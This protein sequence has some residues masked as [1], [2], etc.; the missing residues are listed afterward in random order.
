MGRV[1]STTRPGSYT[2]PRRGASA[3]RQDIPCICSQRRGSGGALGSGDARAYTCLG[4]PPTEE[5]MQE[6]LYHKLTILHY[7]LTSS[8]ERETMEEPIG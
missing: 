5:Y 6:K 7:K 8:E 1:P 2:S 3:G 4:R